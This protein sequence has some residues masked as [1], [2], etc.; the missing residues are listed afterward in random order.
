MKYDQAINLE[1]LV[2]YIYEHGDI[3]FR[4]PKQIKLKNED[5][6]PFTGFTHKPNMVN[7]TNTAKK[8]D[9]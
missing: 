9:L 8:E 4:K 5:V 1:N 2:N 7:K 3:H 6:K